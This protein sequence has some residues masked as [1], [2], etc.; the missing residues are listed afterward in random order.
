M[1]AWLESNEIA[2][3][4]DDDDW[5][6]PETAALWLRFR[7]EALSGRT[8]KWT[9]AQYERV[10]DMHSTAPVP[11]QGL[12]RIFTNADGRTWLSTPDYELVAPFRTDL[13]DPKPS[14]L[15]GRL[16]GGTQ[17]VDATRLGRG[18]ARWPN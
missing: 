13:I 10:L 11:L 18:A 16:A 4:T 6:T 14:L 2:A 7:S 17:V 5:P 1:R 3:L 12:Y 9:I 15:S 8:Q